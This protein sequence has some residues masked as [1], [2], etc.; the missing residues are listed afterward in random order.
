MGRRGG[1]VTYF[2]GARDINVH[3]V[4]V[5]T[6]SQSFED[7][8]GS[9][10]NADA[11]QVEIVNNGGAGIY[12]QCS[13]ADATANDLLIANGGNYECVGVKDRLDNVRLIA[14]GNV[15]VHL[16]ERVVR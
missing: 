15:V 10:L 13:G 8:I 11:E 14:G 6:A 1:D 16:I 2:H 5:T 12:Y 3:R 4:T 9:A 7:L